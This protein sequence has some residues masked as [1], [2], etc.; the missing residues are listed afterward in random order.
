MMCPSEAVLPPAP[1]AASTDSASSSSL[2]FAIS[3]VSS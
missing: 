3:A 2:T 1:L